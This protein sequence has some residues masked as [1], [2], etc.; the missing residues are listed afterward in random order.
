M[1]SFA[2]V[3]AKQH[4]FDVNI[5]SSNILPRF[6]YYKRQK[7]NQD[8]FVLNI[9][10]EPCNVTSDFVFVID[11][12]SSVGEQNFRTSLNFTAHLILALLKNPNSRAGIVT[13][14]EKGRS[15]LCLR[16][17]T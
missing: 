3:H 13:F 4:Y 8:S 5:V 6:L 2:A 7:T 14:A 11:A 16:V 1:A 17:M 15:I 10:A 12:S 9:R